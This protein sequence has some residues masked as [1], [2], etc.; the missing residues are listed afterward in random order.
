MELIEFNSDELAKAVHAANWRFGARGYFAMIGEFALPLFGLRPFVLSLEPST[1][2][3]KAIATALGTFLLASTILG[4]ALGALL[5]GFVG[6]RLSRV[7]SWTSLRRALAGMTAGGLLPG[8]LCGG[9]LLLC[10]NM[11]EI[12]ALYSGIILVVFCGCGA[13]GIVVAERM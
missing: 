13:A 6:D 12:N 7:R 1:M 2:R 3:A 4:A 10:L 11:S 5:G 8:L 9:G